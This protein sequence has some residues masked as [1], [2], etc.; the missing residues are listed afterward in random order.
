MAS[1]VRLRFDMLFRLRVWGDV[2]AVDVEDRLVRET[3]LRALRELR[4]LLML[5][6][7]A[8]SGATGLDGT[9]L[10]GVA[11]TPELEPGITSQ[12][13]RKCSPRTEL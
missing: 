9:V 11:D 2:A 4:P 7:S 8:K 12:W 6:V 3:L 13:V 5:A 1:R 10:E